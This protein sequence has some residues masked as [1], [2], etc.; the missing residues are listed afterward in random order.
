MK[1]E[2]KEKRSALAELDADSLMGYASKQL[3]GVK[4][5]FIS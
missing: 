3:L 2:R 4:R 1:L 5:R